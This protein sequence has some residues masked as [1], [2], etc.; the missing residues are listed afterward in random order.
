VSFNPAAQPAG[1]DP[2]ND[3]VDVRQVHRPQPDVAAVIDARNIEAAAC[4]ITG[5]RG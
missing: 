5:E 4:R 1:G 3:S 2:E